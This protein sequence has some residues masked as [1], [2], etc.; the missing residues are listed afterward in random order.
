MTL[1]SHARILV[2]VAS[3][4]TGCADASVH[5]QF[6]QLQ[7]PPERREKA[8]RIGSFSRADLT[9]GESPAEEAV[10]LDVGV[11]RG[12]A[13]GEGQLCFRLKEKGFEG[14]TF[15]SDAEF[16]ASAEASIKAGSYAIHSHESP[17][18][19]REGAPWPA[20]N[21]KPE[22]VK[23]AG[24]DLVRKKQEYREDG[25]KKY[26]SSSRDVM[27]DVCAPLP[28]LTDATKFISFAILKKKPADN[29]IAVWAIR[30]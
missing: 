13:R 30:P 20:A 14:R 25:S 6:A 2:L 19:F 4:V 10:M 21:V 24:V 29:R 9:A 23:V 12:D 7:E 16:R 15:S 26:R 5:A 1:S 22:D 27:W 3:A 17:D 28:P 18:D 8:K 11:V